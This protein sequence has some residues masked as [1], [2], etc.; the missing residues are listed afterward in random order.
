LTHTRSAPRVVLSADTTVAAV[1]RGASVELVDVAS[2]ARRR[3]ELPDHAEVLA[4]SPDGSWLA[5]GAGHVTLVDCAREPRTLA[6]TR[7]DPPLRRIAVGRGLVVGLSGSEEASMLRAWSGDPLELV[8]AGP[9][10]EGVATEGLALDSEHARAVVWGVQGERADL[11]DGE[12]FVRLCTVGAGAVSELWSGEG[13]PAEPNGFLLPLDGGSLGVYDGDGLV[14]IAAGVWRRSEHLAWGNVEIAVA[15]PDGSH[16]AWVGGDAGDGT[17]VRV[18]E[19]ESGTLVCDAVMP[20]VAL[21]VL[22]VS[23]TGR[24]VVAFGELPDTVRT[25]AVAEGRVEALAVVDLTA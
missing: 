25:F 13:A 11:G 19:V 15:S 8:A 18:A 20:A 12:R 21:P 14:V 16:V 7:V 3:V 17:R 2:G 22:A 9:S 1:P 4:L 10:W 6:H 23:D 24:A 5:A